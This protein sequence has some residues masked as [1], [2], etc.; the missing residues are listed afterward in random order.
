MWR[1]L[2]R[3]MRRPN[4]SGEFRRVGVGYENHEEHEE[5]E[6]RENCA[7]NCKKAKQRTEEFV[8]SR[9]VVNRI[10]PFFGF[11]A[12]CKLEFDFNGV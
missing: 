7:A 10:D 8:Y 5:T 2:S 1:N 6:R 9:H 3:Q 11:L 12:L 4:K